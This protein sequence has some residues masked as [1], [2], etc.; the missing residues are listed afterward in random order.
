MCF[1]GGGW[2]KLTGRYVLQCSDDTH[3]AGT[4]I[5]AGLPNITGAV[6]TRPN[7]TG[8]VNSE[9]GG[10]IPGKQVEGAFTFKTTAGSYE[11]VGTAESN[12]RSHDDLLTF[13]AS[14]SNSIYGKSDTVQPPARIVNVWKRVS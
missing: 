11:N 1:S 12:N 8:K 6:G 7:T 5:E 3:A 2:Q 10:A 14:R 4:V 9:Y 13:N